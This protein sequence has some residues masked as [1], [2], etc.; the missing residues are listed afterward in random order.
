MLRRVRP[1]VCLSVPYRLWRRAVC[2][3]VCVCVCGDVC[4]TQCRQTRAAVVSAQL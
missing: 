1:Y 4:L 2:V 3:C